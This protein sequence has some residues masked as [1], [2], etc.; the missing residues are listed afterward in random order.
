[1]SLTSSLYTGVT[2]LITYGKSLSVI[3]NNLANV[4]TVGFKHSRAEFADLL[5]TSEGHVE[6]GHGV[7][8]ADTSRLFTQGALQTTES[9]TDLAIQGNGLF[10]VKDAA[11][12][13]YYTR[14]GQ[15]HTDKLGHLINPE[16][17][18]VQGFQVDETGRPVG[19]LGNITLGDGVSAPP[20]ITSKLTL[21]ANLDAG[22]SKPKADWPG[23]AGTDASQQEWLAASNFSTSV[24]AYDSLGQ[25][26]DMTFLFRKTD[27]N[28]WEYR[29][30]T[31]IKD[32]EADPKNPDNWKAV[33]DGSLEFTSDGKIDTKASKLNDISLTGLVNGAADLTISAANLS[34]AGFTQY[35]QPSA[36]SLI[37]QDGA[38]SGA[39][40]GIAID[41]QGIVTGRFSNGSSRTLYRVALAEF[42]SVEGLLPVGNTLFAQS[43]ESGNALIGTPGTGGFGT[44]VSGGLELSTVDVTQEFVSLI[45]SQRGFQVNSRIVTVADQLY[46][47]VANLKR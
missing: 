25:G 39:L 1:M 2:G 11:G 18:T 29:A 37:Q 12:G 15:F 44:V 23:G 6:I 46:E 9:V 38:A 45:A 14:A 28:K 40:V 5:T 8:L 17:Y 13:T 33:G 47:E 22:S 26:H 4:N 30:V 42:P 43:S 7:R 32:V 19:G 20:T 35:A 21:T 31:P 16:G 41:Q 3:G 36:V 24:T 27:V 10:V 34:V